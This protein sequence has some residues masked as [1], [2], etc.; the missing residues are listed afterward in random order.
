MNEAELRDESLAISQQ[1]AAH[2]QTKGRRPVAIR[3]GLVPGQS[4]RHVDHSR[5][6]D[7]GAVRR[8]PRR[9]LQVQITPTDEAFVDPLVPPG[10]HSG[11][12]F[13]DPNYPIV[14]AA[15]EFVIAV[16][17]LCCMF[18]I[19]WIGSVR[20]ASEAAFSCRNGIYRLKFEQFS[21]RC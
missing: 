3:P 1:L 14:G 17:K 19:C 16:G 21:K 8:Q 9:A 15:G 13:R 7:D 5:P 6:A 18:R 10:E 12:G 2:C 20:L 4:D 11:K